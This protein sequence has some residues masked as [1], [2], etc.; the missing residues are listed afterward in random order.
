MKEDSECIKKGDIVWAKVKGFPWWPGEVKRITTSALGNNDDEKEKQVTINFIGHNSH[1]KLPLSKVE[2]F[3]NKYDQYSKTRK[4]MLIKSIEKAK[5]MVQSKRKISNKSE[6]ENCS[7]NSS[8]ESKSKSS[9][10]NNSSSDISGSSTP[11]QKNKRTILKNISLQERKL[12]D[13]EKITSAST[14]ASSTKTKPK[15]IKI[16]IN[17]NVT[18]NN[19]NTV[20]ISS[21]SKDMNSTKKEKETVLQNIDKSSISKENSD[22]EEDNESSE[23]EEQPEEVLKVLIDNLLKYQIEMTTSSSLKYIVNT[24]DEIKELLDKYTFADLYSITKDIMPL[25]MSFT[26]N[27]NSDVL[28]KSSEIISSLTQNIKKEIFEINEDKTEFSPSQLDESPIVTK[29][30]K[31]EL[32][33]MLNDKSALKKISQ[34]N[35]NDI[36]S[37][38]QNKILKRNKPNTMTKRKTKREYL[39]NEDIDFKEIYENFNKVISHKEDKKAMD[40]VKNI[41]EEFYKNT[42]NKYHGLEIKQAI[43]RKEVC[44][45]IFKILKQ[46]FKRAKDEQ[47]QKLVVF[48][49]YQ[50]RKQDPNLGKKYFGQ[51]QK[52][53]ELMKDVLEE[54]TI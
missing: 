36:D 26:Y 29:E 15:N 46:L 41:T 13:L 54:K 51:I 37:L 28:I 2:N 53:I 17:I 25:L 40:E 27:K 11:E 7:S 4:K 44:L 32:I 52:I 38:K 8:S 33:S 50:I 3:E 35:S 34:I 12:P 1:V 45:K 39:E 19:H 31:E 6:N 48:F 23:E 16:N 22:K 47:L 20:N 14:F 43:K 24:L 49:E 30:L 10:D 9:Y 18:N 42:Y 5:R 21:F